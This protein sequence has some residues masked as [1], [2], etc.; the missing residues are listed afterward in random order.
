MF[1]NTEELEVILREGS[2]LQGK[3]NRSNKW[4]NINCWSWQLIKKMKAPHSLYRW[5]VPNIGL[6]HIFL[7]FDFTKMFVSFKEKM[8]RLKK[9]WINLHHQ[10]LKVLSNTTSTTAKTF[11]HSIF[12][13]YKFI[14]SSSFTQTSKF[15]HMVLRSSNKWI[16]ISMK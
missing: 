9:M 11:F 7:S 5:D 8:W 3:T 2:L 4:G 6:L 13:M 1:T 12:L 14:S 16:P 10:I 15:K